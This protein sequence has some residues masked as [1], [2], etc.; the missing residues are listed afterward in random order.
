MQIPISMWLEDTITWSW[1]LLRKKQLNIK[2]SILISVMTFYK[3]KYDNTHEGFF[4]KQSWEK[5]SLVY[6]LCLTFLARTMP[7]QRKD[8]L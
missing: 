8:L 5:D 6:G 1:A 2:N 3:I 4:L 7:D